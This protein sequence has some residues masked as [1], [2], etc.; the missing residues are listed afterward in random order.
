M[1]AAFLRALLWEWEHHPKRLVAIWLGL[2]VIGV[3]QSDGFAFVTLAGVAGVV[4]VLVVLLFMV[5]LA[6]RWLRRPGTMAPPTTGRWQDYWTVET[7]ASEP[8]DAERARGMTQ[9]TW[10]WN[11]AWTNWEQLHRDGPRLV[12][13]SLAG[14]PDGLGEPGTQDWRTT[15]AAARAV[16]ETVAAY[17]WAREGYKR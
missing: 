17:L 3:A 7:W 2:G 13:G 9:T 11:I 10:G 1:I 8:T 16:G 4:V 14:L 15:E 5:P 12:Y 6:L